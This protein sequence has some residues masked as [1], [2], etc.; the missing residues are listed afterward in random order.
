MAPLGTAHGV[1]LTGAGLEAFRQGSAIFS[2]HMALGSGMEV[3]DAEMEGL[4]RAAE[5]LREWFHL[6]GDNHGVRRV[7]FFADNTGALQRIYKGTPG[8][9]Q[10]CSFRFR[11]TIHHILDAYPDLRVTLEWVPGHHNIRGN[12]TADALA[13]QGTEE[14]PVFP[15]FTSAAFTMNTHR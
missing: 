15:G 6:T 13:K 9:D 8:Y 7:F 1:R 2:K 3:Y 12:D 11:S 10:D 4:A 5:R 14:D